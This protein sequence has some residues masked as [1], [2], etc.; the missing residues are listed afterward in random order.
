ME[1]RKRQGQQGQGEEVKKPFGTSKPPWT[2]DEVAAFCL[3]TCSALHG[4]L[5]PS[6]LLHLCCLASDSN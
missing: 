3:R 5:Y 1:E 2:L 6:Q 4:P